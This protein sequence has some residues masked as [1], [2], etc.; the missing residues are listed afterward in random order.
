MIRWKVTSTREFT[1]NAEFKTKKEALSH[2]EHYQN[3]YGDSMAN[4]LKIEKVITKGIPKVK[5]HFKVNRK[6]ESHATIHT[7]P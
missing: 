6:Y 3:R 2:I 5:K 1:H 7:I 4:I